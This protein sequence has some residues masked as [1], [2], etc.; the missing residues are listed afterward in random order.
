MCISFDNEGRFSL[1]G[2]FSFVLSTRQCSED[3]LSWVHWVVL[4]FLSLCH[5]FTYL[6]G[7]D[8]PLADGSN[9][10]LQPPSFTISVFF[11][12][13]FFY[14]LSSFLSNFIYLFLYNFLLFTTFSYLL[15]FLIVTCTIGGSEVTVIQ[16][17]E[18]SST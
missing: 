13:L 15:D 10:P 3:C 9:H 1:F 12:F 16:N 7:S 18:K 8:T 2:N 11:L 14:S 17:L 5:L 4:V 6:T